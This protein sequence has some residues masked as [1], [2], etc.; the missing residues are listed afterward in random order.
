LD[1]VNNIANH[2]LNAVKHDIALYPLDKQYLKKCEDFEKKLTE[3]RRIATEAAHKFSELQN[4]GNTRKECVGA[5]PQNV[6]AAR[7][8]RKD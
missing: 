8:A 2:C 6:A 4:L 3:L 1:S 7:S 5:T